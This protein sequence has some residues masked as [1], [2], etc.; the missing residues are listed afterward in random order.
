MEIQ[1]IQ[2]FLFSSRMRS[3]DIE[4]VRVCVCVWEREKHDD[5]KADQPRQG[6]KRNKQENYFEVWA[7]V[8]SLFFDIISVAWNVNFFAEKS[9]FY[10]GKLKPWGTNIW[11]KM[12]NNSQ[13]FFLIFCK[14]KC[15]PES[16][17]PWQ[18]NIY[19][20]II[21]YTYQ[22]KKERKTILQH[23]RSVMSTYI[24][25]FLSRYFH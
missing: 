4:S 1:L 10:W 8:V 21:W 17:L 22:R 12:T 24:K 23:V 13:R 6:N 16:F 3:R 19:L 11:R 25:V 14:R 20:Y 5:K 15:S 9:S 7:S 18:I 2:L